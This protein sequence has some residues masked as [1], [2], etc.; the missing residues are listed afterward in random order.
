MKFPEEGEGIRNEEN[1]WEGFTLIGDGVVMNINHL[2]KESTMQVFSKRHTRMLVFTVLSL[3]LGFTSSAFAAVLGG[4][5]AANKS[6]AVR[7]IEVMCAAAA[8][9]IARQP[10]AETKILGFLRDGFAN[11]KKRKDGNT[12]IPEALGVIR[13]AAITAVAR[14]PE[15]EG[16]LLG[17]IE[18]CEL[19]LAGLGKVSF[20]F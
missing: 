15:A 6:S 12:G 2:V 9:A 5:K 8:D 19:A 11:I 18:E 14:Q 1:V 4:D 16:K 17:L 3:I 20:P 10:E 13:G 7:G